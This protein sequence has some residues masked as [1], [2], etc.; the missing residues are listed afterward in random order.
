MNSLNLRIKDQNWLIDLRNK[1][2]AA[3]SNDSFLLAG[4]CLKDSCTC[5]A[6][7]C[8]LGRDTGK[9][10]EIHLKDLG[11]HIITRA[12]SYLWTFCYACNRLFHLTCVGM[13]SGDFKGKNRSSPLQCQL[14]MADENNETA[15]AYYESGEWTKNMEE[16]KEF[17]LKSTGS[18]Q[19][20]LNKSTDGIEDVE[21]TYKERFHHQKEEFEKVARKLGQVAE[22]KRSSDL[23]LKAQEVQIARM[24]S[25]LES[26]K[27]FREEMLAMKAQLSESGMM[28]KKAEVVD[29]EI[30]N[31]ETAGDLASSTMVDL[32]VLTADEVL[33]QY[34]LN[35]SGNNNKPESSMKSIGQN[36]PVCNKSKSFID[37]INEEDLTRAE[38]LKLEQVQAQLATSQAQR[39]IS[40]TMNLEIKRKA[41]PKIT[42]FDGDARKWI[43][44][45][46]DV[47]RYKE[48][49]KYK[50]DVMK[51]H[52]MQAL[53][54]IAQARVRDIIDTATF[55]TIMKIL[56][57]SFG[58]PTKII[59]KCS[60]DILSLKLSRDLYKDDVMLI[61]TRIQAYFSACRYA[62]VPFANSNQLA[63]HIFDQLNIS[64]KQMYRHES[65]LA[66]PG[67]SVR[68]IDLKTLY[69]FL[70]NLAKDLEDKK[71]DDRR[72]E[73]RHHS[74][75]RRRSEQTCFH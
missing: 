15:I 68:L 16:R 25:E 35:E 27:L 72:Y 11:G 46:Q 30:N 33:A 37:G 70:E 44:F 63:R 59:D 32:T 43:K 19:E 7:I 60:N 29:R 74:L 10:K 34:Y 24:Q 53:Q 62:S 61:N 36:A 69:L 23:K 55:E 45:V 8:K 21:E 3:F 65:R 18:L 40:E 49:G 13:S 54:G 17:F 22:E 39:E 42:P 47:Q 28:T 26:L 73:E 58:D 51:L 75:L 67:A 2:P 31:K 56:G 5:Q 71:F 52:V 48:V 6:N 9:G 41:L 12:P 1:D 38:R 14:C 20:E 4:V 66:N 57:D 50:D 64:Y